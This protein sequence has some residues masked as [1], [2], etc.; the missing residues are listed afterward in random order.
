MKKRMFSL[1]LC[2]VLTVYLAIPAFGASEYGSYYDETEVLWNQT[3]EALGTKTL[4]SM[5]EYYGLDI[6]VD[7]LTS[8][9]GNGVEVSARQ[10]YEKYEYGLGDGK[11]GVSLTVYVIEDEDGWYVDSWT[12]YVGG[13][14]PAWQGL[15]SSLTAALAPAFADN[16]WSL[17]LNYDITAMASAVALMSAGISDYVKNGPTETPANPVAPSD[18]VGIDFSAEGNVIDLTGVLLAQEDEA[19]ESGIAAMSERY[20]CGCYIVVTDNLYAYGSNAPDAVINLYHDNSL[21]IGS[22]RDGILLLLDTVNREFAFFVYGDNAEYIFDDYGQDLL[23]DVFLDDF[24]EDAWYG[25]LEDFVYECGEYMELAAQ[26][27]PVRASKGGAYGM[28]ILV[29]LIVAAIVCFV[30]VSQMKSVFVGAE[31]SAYVVDGTVVFTER[32]DSFLYKTTITRDLSNDDKNT[33]SFSG[34]G[35][36]GRSGS[37]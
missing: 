23:E 5:A 34:G 4:P 22:G 27:D 17:G 10:I 35:G 2:L 26:G 7:V 29:A 6:R 25:G 15:E 36:S 21:G 8:V 30:L 13:S 32:H 14:D 12:V 31:A 24:A 1:L 9:G 16:A 18:P 3:L 28:A 33:S 11:D 19:L 20:Q 37:F